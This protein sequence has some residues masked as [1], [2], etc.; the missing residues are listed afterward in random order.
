MGGQSTCNFEVQSNNKSTIFLLNRCFVI[1]GYLLYSNV[2]FFFR[3][4][5]NCVA[6]GV[7]DGHVAIVPSLKAPGFIKVETS[8]GEY[9]PIFHCTGLRLKSEYLLITLDTVSVLV[10]RNLPMTAFI[11]QKGT[12]PTHIYHQLLDQPIKWRTLF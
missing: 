3:L 5:Q 4:Y 6:A 2:G 1:W 11:S 10:V 8:T 9:G 7:M 12:R